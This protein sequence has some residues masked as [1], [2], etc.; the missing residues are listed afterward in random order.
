MTR[1]DYVGFT[2]DSDEEN[3]PRERG[4]G[5]EREEEEEEGEDCRENV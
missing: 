3:F 5:G 2:V 4:G 1:K